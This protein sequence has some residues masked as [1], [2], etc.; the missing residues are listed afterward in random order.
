MSF[1]KPKFV[2][3]AL[4]SALVAALLTGGC[5]GGAFSGSA[6]S[7]GTGASSSGG[8]SSGGNQAGGAVGTGAGTGKA[9]DGPEDCDDKDACTTDRCNAD[10]TCGTSPKCVDGQRCC[11]GD[12]AECCKNA[13]CDD[14]IACTTNT[15]FAGQC[16]YVPND[17]MCKATQ[18]CS[19][20]DGCHEKQACGVLTSE[21]QDIC[22]D[23]SG[24]TVDSCVNHF[25]EHTQCP[26][27]NANL[28]CSDTI[29]GACCNDSQCDTDPDPCKVGS[30]QDGKC[31]VV[32]LC[33]NGLTCCPSADGKTATCGKCCSADV[34]NDQIGCT[35]DKCGGGQCS[36]TP[37]DALCPAG[38]ICNP[39]KKMCTQAAECG[40]DKPC[41]PLPCQTNPRC[42]NGTCHFDGCAQ[43]TKCCG[44][45]GC[46]VCCGDAEC[47]DNI[48][49]PCT[50]DS[51]DPNTGCKHVPD[52]SL[53]GPGQVCSPVANCV[54]GCKLDSDCRGGVA[55]M[56]LPSAGGGGIMYPCEVKSCVNGM[57]QSKTVDCGDFQMCCPGFVGC[58]LNC[59]VATQ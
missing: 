33:T 56:A 36:N 43:G 28:C 38:F 15:C 26:D 25:C 4:V 41:T 24:C 18:Y 19:T 51:C 31:T 34:C 37:N 57:C 53:C 9:C 47:D 16:M 2:L 42:D 14:G 22:D 54:G 20:K 44:N 11:S 48:T 52:D 5:G 32:D 39:D 59:N 23:G 40:P 13:D 29:C 45:A 6:S 7:A 8:S 30:C 58:A 1:L 17:T 49:V 21:P 12:C 27:R 10:G 50:K 35:E 46:A 3:F 55:T